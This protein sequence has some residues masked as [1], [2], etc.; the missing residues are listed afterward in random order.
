MN[1]G[2]GV[3]TQ[4]VLEDDNPTEGAKTLKAAGF[5]AVDF[6]LH[7][8][9]KNKDIYRFS[10]NRFFEKTVKESEAFFTPHKEALE[11]AG[12]DV[13][14]MH[15]PYPVYVPK[16]SRRLN[17]YLRRTVAPKSMLLCRFFGCKHIVIH[18][19]KLAYYV[20]SEEKEW[21][22]TEE[23]LEELAPLAKELGVTMCIEN[24]YD[25]VGDRLTEGPCCD[26]VKAVKRIDAM[27]EKYGAEVLGFCFDTGH[28]NLA[29]LDFEEFI[30]TLG[31]RLKVLHIH[32]NDGW[33]DLHQIPFVFTKTRENKSATDWE[34]FIRGLKNINYKGVLN[35][36]TGPALT[37]F[38]DD[39]KCETL[40]FIADIGK[41][42][43]N[44]LDTAYV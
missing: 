23:F 41:Y 38:P 24:L 34:G 14:Q 6:S 32:D 15:M 29:H 37:A 26:A 9:L 12:I 19:F 40:K 27:N 18:G 20:G 43:A 33:R 7:G 16:G 30:T 44:K 2:I 17:E 1:L 31:D 28:G 36:E 11:Q 39:L 10:I 42:F 4:N 35:F 5:D 22:A 25:G 21:E 3:Q 13:W 8:Y